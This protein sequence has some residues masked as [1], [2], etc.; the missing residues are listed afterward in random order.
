LKLAD[1]EL[2]K[3]DMILEKQTTKKREKQRRKP[4]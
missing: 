2:D 3:Y 4:T 1:F